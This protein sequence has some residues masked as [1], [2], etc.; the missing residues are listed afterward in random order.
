MAVLARR[1]F[2]WVFAGLAA[3]MLGDASLLLMPAILAKTLTGSNSAAGLVLLFFTVPMVFAPL[4]GVVIDRVDRRRLLIVA[5]LV[6]AVAVAPLALVS[7]RSTAWLVYPVAVG[8]GLSYTVIFSALAGLLKGMLPA[9]ELAGANAL[10]TSTRQGLRLLGPLLGVALYAG[11]GLWSVVVFDV[12]TFVVAAGCFAMLPSV[13]RPPRRAWVSLRVEVGAGARHVWGEPVLR[14][15]MACLS[16]FFLVAGA[17]ESLIFAVIEALGRGPEFT[18]FTS[19]ALGVGAVGCGLGSARLVARFGEP[20]MVGAGVFLYG[21]AIG[22]WLVPFEAV[23][24]G[25]MALAGAGLTLSGVAMRTLLQRRSPDEVMGRVST[26]YDAVAG[27]GQL[28]SVGAGALLALWVDYRVLVA[29]VSVVCL[30]APLV[31]LQSKAARLVKNH[32]S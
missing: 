23:M 13:P 4:L 19:V 11:V 12:L 2:R 3:S 25:A 21:L 18:A 5:C 14:R 26:A 20:A 15:A 29:A 8:M 22:L 16:L 7:G 24:V 27:A 28:V 6:S 31:N 32:P 10:L 9:S 30:L 1:D 17:T